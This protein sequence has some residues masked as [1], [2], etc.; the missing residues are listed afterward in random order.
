MGNIFNAYWPSQVE[1]IDAA[2]SPIT[3]GCS[4]NVAEVQWC[5]YTRQGNGNNSNLWTLFQHEIKYVTSFFQNVSVTLPLVKYL[6][7]YEVN[8]L[9][10]GGV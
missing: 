6:N 2:D 10:V 4:Y 9:F 1:V 3:S 8:F 7:L 5:P